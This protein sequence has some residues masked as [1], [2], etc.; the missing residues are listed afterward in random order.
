MQVLYTVAYHDYEGP[1]TDHDERERI[2]RDLSDNRVLILRNHGLLT[3]GQTVAEAFVWMYRAERACRMQLAFQ[4]CGAALHPISDEVQ[5]LSM[6]RSRK[7]T[8][9][10]GHRPT[11][12]LEWPAWLRRL[13]RLDPSYKS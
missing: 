8:S 1:A 2:V 7:F 6:D 11:G 12:K 9:A 13:E 10:G 3:V 5:R 4:Q